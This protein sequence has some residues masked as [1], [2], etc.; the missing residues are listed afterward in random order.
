M[1]GFSVLLGLVGLLMIYSMTYATASQSPLLARQ[2]VFFLIGFCLLLFFSSI[3]YRHLYKIGALSYI[4]AVALLLGVLLFGL[5]VKG[6][7][8]WFAL[9]FFQ[10]QPVELAKI[11]LIIY[12][13]AYFQKN[14]GQISRFRV[15]L[16]SVFLVSIPVGLTLIQPD[17][18]SALV[19]LAIWLGMLIA[20]GAKKRHLLWLL[21]FFVVLS[22]FAWVG[23]LKDYQK[24]RVLSF[25]DPTADPQGRGYNALQ[26]VIAAGSGGLTGRGLARGIVSGLRFL[27][28]RQTDFIFASLAEE[29]GFVGTSFFL[30]VLLGWFFRMARIIERTSDN[31]S[32]LLS[33][34]IF[35]YLFFQTAINIGMNIG[36]LPITG[37]PLPL[38]SYGGSSLLVAMSCIGILQ[39]I[40]GHNQAFQSR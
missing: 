36:L 21:L 12:L 16:V 6:S 24:D 22:S 25:L 17:L 2:A 35:C 34:G 20:S 29:L 7:L 5:S 9:G 15:V 32:L 28:E 14:I 27:P 4:S 18:G 40:A 38:I 8:R 13:A 1:L 33:V 39:S 37:I 30:L 10:V 3:N 19:L 31:F 11:A 23:F 26:S